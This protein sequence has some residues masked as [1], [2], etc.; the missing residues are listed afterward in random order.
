MPNSLASARVNRVSAAA[1][2]GAKGVVVI[3]IAL[4]S[5]LVTCG[6]GSASRV[7]AWAALQNRLS[8][9]PADGLPVEAG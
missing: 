4:E 7:A 8:D 1:E 9:R 2:R 6:S 3:W 5:A